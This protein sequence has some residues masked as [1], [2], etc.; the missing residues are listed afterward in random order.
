[1]ISCHGSVTSVLTFASLKGFMVRMEVKEPCSEYL[2]QNK[3]FSK[4]DVPVL[5]YLFKFAIIHAQELE[6]INFESEGYTYDKAADAKLDFFYES[7]L[8]QKLWLESVTGG[9]IPVCPSVTNLSFFNLNSATNLLDYVAS[10]ASNNSSVPLHDLK[11]FI[12]EQIQQQP[13]EF[14]LGVIVQNLINNS[15]TYKDFLEDNT[16]NTEVKRAATIFA[17]VQLV[18]LFLKNKIIHLDLHGGKKYTSISK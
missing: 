10:T 11:Q 3:Q 9:R 16:K 17:C 6:L 12:T 14:S 2:Q 8:Q 18:R 13:N 15:T 5:Q 7:K 4:F 1:M